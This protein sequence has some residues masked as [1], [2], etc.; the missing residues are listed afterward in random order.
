MNEIHDGDRL[1]LGDRVLERLASH[2]TA[3]LGAHHAP[4]ASPAI[5]PRL[6]SAFD[7]VRSGRVHPTRKAGKDRYRV[8]EISFVL[9]AAP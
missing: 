3:V 6:V 4:I 8:G 1:D 2:L 9:R 5:L 7:D